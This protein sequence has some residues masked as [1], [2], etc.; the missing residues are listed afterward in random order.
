VWHASV[1]ARFPIRDVC[2][3]EVLRQLDGLGDASL[4]EWGEWS[5]DAYYIRRRLSVREQV[6]VGPVV[7][8]R[9]T[10]EA[11]ERLQLFAL[12]VPYLPPAF[13]AMALDEVGLVEMER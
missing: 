13:W 2:R 1:S 8:V 7:D 12:A 9:F 5:G 11:V 4:G 6:S 3:R 10:P